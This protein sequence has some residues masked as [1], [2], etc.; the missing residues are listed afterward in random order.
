[1][2]HPPVLRQQGLVLKSQA[3]SKINPNTSPKRS[4]GPTPGADRRLHQ[5]PP[6]P[7]CLAALSWEP[8]T[9]GHPTQVV[10]REGQLTLSPILSLTPWRSSLPSPAAAPLAQAGPGVVWGLLWQGEDMCFHPNLD[11][12]DAWTRYRPPCDRRHHLPLVPVGK[13][14]A[15][16]AMWPLRTYVKHSCQRKTQ[17]ACSGRAQML[18]SCS[19]QVVRKT[20]PLKVL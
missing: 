9:Q 3:P 18:S 1:M 20:L 4:A 12:L 11:M 14:A 6:G 10:R 5:A 13:T 2:A 19:F 7:S 17:R 8:P 16:T 15:L